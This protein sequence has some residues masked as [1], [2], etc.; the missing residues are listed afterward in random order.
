[1]CFEWRYKVGCSVPA[2]PSLQAPSPAGWPNQGPGALYN[3]MI[4]PLLPLACRGVIQY[5]GVNNGS[6]AH[7]FCQLLPV[8]LSSWR[9]AFGPDFAFVMVQE[10]NFMAQ[11]K[12]RDYVEPEDSMSLPLGIAP[13]REAVLKA[14]SSPRTAMA[15]TIDI[16]ESWDIHPNNKRVVGQRLALAALGGIYGRKTVYSG[17][18][19]ESM[20]AKGSRVRVRFRHVGGGLVSRG[21]ELRQFMVAGADR[22]FVWAKAAI[23][24]DTV[25]VSSDQVK[26]PV[27]VRYAFWADPKDANLYNREGLPASPFRTDDW[28]LATNSVKPK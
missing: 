13:I 15:V 11:G 20:K 17:P 9:K 26:A 22:K 27:A 19:Y 3:G 2:N 24:G 6:R 4:A 18:L 1:M 10:P 16:G 8:L 23:E 21:G 5:H 14:L 28:D 25:V 12:P 7:E